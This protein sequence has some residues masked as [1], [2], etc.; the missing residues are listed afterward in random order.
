MTHEIQFEVKCM[1][2]EKN[3]ISAT[4]IFDEID[5]LIED[6]LYGTADN[7]LADAERYCCKSAILV[8]KI[9]RH[10]NR[11]NFIGLVKAYLMN[12][13][14]YK[15]YDVNYF[16]LVVPEKFTVKV[17][18]SH[19]SDA[20]DVLPVTNLLGSVSLCSVC[21]KYYYNQKIGNINGKLYCRHCVETAGYY[22][23]NNCKKF[24]RVSE[25]CPLYFKE[26][27]G[28]IRSYSTD[29]L[30]LIHRFGK[31][32]EDIKTNGEYLYY[33]VELEVLPRPTVDRRF[34]ARACGK[35]LFNH[36]ILKSDASLK[37]NNIVTGYEIVTIPATLRYHRKFLW[38]DFFNKKYGDHVAAKYVRS[39]D[40]K[41]CGIHVHLTKACLTQMQLSKLLVFYHESNNSNF[42]S[43][44]AGRKVGPDAYYCRAVSKK[45]DL[46]TVSSCQ[47]HHEAVTVSD[48]NNGKTAEVRIFRGNATYHGIIR[49]IEFVD[50]TV[51]WCGICS[52]QD[53]LDY[54]KFLYWFNTPE[55]KSQYP[56]LR[57]HLV[58]L[59]FL[60]PR[61]KSGIIPAKAQPD[62]TPLEL[63]TA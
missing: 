48:R 51:K 18:F 6:T 44:I 41:V 5:A 13:T 19:G 22:Y 57:K 38:N 25:G 49:C 3:K 8:E 15:F 55:I 58:Q 27:L 43:R 40:T 20:Y 47:A 7:L 28:Y 24:H 12:K 32:N 21:N 2:V 39:W 33:G 54:K 10:R 11:A 63:R 30:S 31:T 53:V 56:E 46:Y 26:D 4:Q 61:F 9:E 14:K 36:A 1:P 60:S 42:L 29:V 52:V 45:L 16:S 23:C 50:A 62:V 59:H 17:Y 37:E 35:A 34:S